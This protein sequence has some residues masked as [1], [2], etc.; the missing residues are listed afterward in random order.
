MISSTPN[1]ATVAFTYTGKPTYFRLIVKN[2]KVLSDIK[3]LYITSSPYTITGL[4]PNTYYT[5]DTYS[6][7][8]TG[9]EYLKTYV[10]TLLTLNEGPPLNVNITNIQYNS[11][12]LNFE[13]SIGSPSTFIL[14]VINTANANNVLATGPTVRSR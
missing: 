13:S 14:D 5:V 7:F 10:N 1:T 11:A 2:I 12:V 8:N 9:N 4:T 3:T 6:I